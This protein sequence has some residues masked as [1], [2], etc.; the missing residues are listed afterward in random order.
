MGLK[1]NL[2]QRVKLVPFIDLCVVCTFW[3]I[4]VLNLKGF[5]CQLKLE[6]C[7]SC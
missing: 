7:V 2:V 6:V 1:F 3:L 4:L 5:K